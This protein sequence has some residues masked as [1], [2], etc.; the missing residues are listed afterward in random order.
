MWKS[1]HVEGKGTYKH[2]RDDSEGFFE[3]EGTWTHQ[4]SSDFGLTD[5]YSFRDD[6]YHL[7]IEVSFEGIK[8]VDHKP[9]AQWV[10]EERKRRK[11]RLLRH[12]GLL[13]L[14]SNLSEDNNNDSRGGGGGGK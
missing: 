6:D 11:Q 13:Q 14:L 1:G 9:M 10:P 3:I 8:S 2:R 12:L 7:Q 4:R 5:H